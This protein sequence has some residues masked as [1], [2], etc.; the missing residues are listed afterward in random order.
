MPP[1]RI[2]HITPYSARAW[3]YGG[4][5]RV[6][7]ALTKALARL[8]HSVTVCATDACT[9]KTR[10][11]ADDGR[12]AADDGLLAS[13]NGGRTAEVELRI[14]PNV[15]NRLA[16]HAQLFLPRGLRGYLRAHAHQ[17]DVAHIHACRNVPGVLA[18]RAL[19]AAGVPY[20]LAP[21]GT[22]PLLE[23]RR[24][25]KRVFD[26]VAGQSV[27][28]GAAR[29]LAVSAAET[30]QLSDMGIQSD[31]IRQIA[32]PLDLDEFPCLP[33]RGGFRRDWS[34]GDAPV[35]LFLG[36]ITPRKRL[37]TL[38]RA[39]ATLP[40]RAA[41]L[42]VAG[43]D[44]GGLEAMRALARALGIDDRLTCTGLLEG[45]RRL[46]ALGDADVVVYASEDEV[47]GLVP[48][49]ALLCGTPVVVGND[50]GCGEVI[51][52]VGG[53]QTVAPGDKDALMRAIAAVLDAPAQARAAAADAGQHVRRL[54]GSD[55]I[56]ADLAEVYREIL[57]PRRA[58]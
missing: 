24:L 11:A 28:D 31:R 19:A 43:N 26:A 21:N 45:H 33:P 14:F 23:R 38:V 8:G 18:A 48:L 35:V 57:S 29:V 27:V 44:M 42:V 41:R 50:S 6:A 9:A 16:Y 54:F 22:A 2:L 58:A 55:V 5:P 40:H 53:Q 13:G 36:K 39:F 37:D 10:L 52:A 4:I 1:L 12:R 49:E 56:A 47:F 17:F 34:L 32:N 46:A 15:S 51:R 7:G 3:A 20:V 30:R 25:A